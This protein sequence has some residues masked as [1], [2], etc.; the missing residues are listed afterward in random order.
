MSSPAA[1]CKQV[2]VIQKVT[3]LRGMQQHRQSGWVSSRICRPRRTSSPLR[4][5]IAFQRLRFLRR[6]F[7]LLPVHRTLSGTRSSSLSCAN[8]SSTSRDL[9][10]SVCLSKRNQHIRHTARAGNYPSSSNM[11][12]MRLGERSPRALS[13][14]CPTKGIVESA[15]CPS[16]SHTRV[17]QRLLCLA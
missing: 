15:V 7:H 10:A 17:F 12:C 9:S 14:A 4:F 16:Q 3:V 13:S 11:A 1:R 2:R 8:F 5:S 6:N